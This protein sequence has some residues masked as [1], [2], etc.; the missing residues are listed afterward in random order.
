MQNS[1][2]WGNSPNQLITQEASVTVR[3]CDIQRGSG[4][5]GHINSDPL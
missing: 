3:Y 1:I 5:T 4:G 2:L